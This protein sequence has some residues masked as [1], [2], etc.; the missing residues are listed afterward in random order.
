MSKRLSPSFNGNLNPITSPLMMKR[1]HVHFGSYA[2][3]AALS[4][5]ARTSLGNGGMESK[6]SLSGVFSPAVAGKANNTSAR[7]NDNR[8]AA[9]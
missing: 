5:D 9:R 2:A 6:Y 3:R 7:I 1:M 8:M 4:K